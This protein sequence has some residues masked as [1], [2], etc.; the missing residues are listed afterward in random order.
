MGRPPRLAKATSSGCSARHDTHHEAHTLS[1]HTWP[2]MSAG[3]NWLPGA[4]GD[5]AELG[6]G[7]A[8]QRRGHLARV[9]LRPTARNTTRTQEDGRGES[10]NVSRGGSPAGQAAARR[11]A[12][13]R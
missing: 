11:P 5:E 7:F 1:S 8:D 9:A 10:G 2:R 3:E 13:R 4:R 6:A 12:V